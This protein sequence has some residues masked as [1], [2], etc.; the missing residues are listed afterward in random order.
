MFRVTRARLGLAVAGA[1]L[2]LL[3]SAPAAMAAGSPNLWPNGASGNRANTEWRTGSY[4]N[5]ALTRRTLIK[6]YLTAGQ[7]LMLG[8]SAMGQGLSDIRVY[9]PNRVSGP[10]GTET[11]PAVADF[12]CAAQRLLAGAPPAQGIITSR[13]EE[14]AGPDPELGAGVEPGIGR[15]GHVHQM[16]QHRLGRI[17]RIAVAAEA[18]REVETDMA[19]ERHRRRDV[20]DLEI[21]PRLRSLNQRSGPSPIPLILGHEHLYSGL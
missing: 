16:Q 2:M 14:L 7:V 11:I 21:D 13:A 15:A 10:I 20:I 5:G 12:S 8:S 1:V 19:V 9:N 18:D 17:A 6:A 4:G 3:L